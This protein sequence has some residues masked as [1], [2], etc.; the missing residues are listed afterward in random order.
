MAME[1][2]G[3]T[4]ASSKF[5]LDLGAN[6]GEG[7]TLRMFQEDGYDGLLVEG[8]P[9]HLNTLNEKV[10]HKSVQKLI[11][12]VT[13]GTIVSILTQSSVPKNLQYLKID[14]DADDCAVLLVFID[15]GWV[16]LFFKSR[17]T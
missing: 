10:P 6:D 12:Y 2:F 5:V 13:P 8:D 1:E 3:T 14:L 7:P 17:S 4:A 9:S 16:P 11:S 15:S